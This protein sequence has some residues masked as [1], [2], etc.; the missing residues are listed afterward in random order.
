MSGGAGS[1]AA[2]AAA[3]SPLDLSQ[4]GWFHG[5]VSR[6]QAEA[7]L[8]GCEAGSF[9][10]RESSRKPGAFSLTVRSVV[11]PLLP[12]PRSPAILTGPPLLLHSTCA[13]DVGSSPNLEFYLPLL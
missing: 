5:D 12:P 9:V 2:A 3:L 6:E 13:L 10:V 11:L 7:L 4:Y 8:D 1:G